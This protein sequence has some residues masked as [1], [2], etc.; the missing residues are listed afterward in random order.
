MN[1]L[2]FVVTPL[3]TAGIFA[4]LYWAIDK[5]NQALKL[6]FLFATLTF[7]FTGNAQNLNL[8]QVNN[9]TIGSG[10]ITGMAQPNHWA[11]IFIIV[12]TVA[13]IL[14]YWF[15]AYLQKMNAGKYN[16]ETGEYNDY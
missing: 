2:V 5:R 6:L 15:R 1:E 7:I 10:A 12:V 4:Y 13:L 16:R 11:L 9:G 3:L 8:A 14:V